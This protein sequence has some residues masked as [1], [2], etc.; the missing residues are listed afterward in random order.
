M[1]AAR[2]IRP[3]TTG[4]TLVEMLI[5]LVIFGIIT[6][7]GVALLSFSVRAEEMA[8]RQLEALSAVRRSGAL[9]TGDLAQAVRR[10]WRD[11]EGRPNAAFVGNRSNSQTLMVFV[12]AGWDNP[13]GLPRASLQRVEYRFQGNRL[14]RI[15]FAHVDGSG[16]AQVA[17]LMEDVERVTVRYR[18]ARGTWREDWTP[19]NPTELPTAVEVTAIVPRFGEVRQVFA[20]GAAG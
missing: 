13:D 14:I 15:G 7:G 19:S 8:D 6:A 11:N 3:G 18:E 17:T 20:V 12:R 1:R 10:S 9:L 2:P 4:F 16:A 5:A